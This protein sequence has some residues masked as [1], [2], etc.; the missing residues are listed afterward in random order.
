MEG[1]GVS[2]GGRGDEGGKSSSSSV[3]SRFVTGLPSGGESAGR[4]VL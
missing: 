2:D 4:L 1:G 3:L